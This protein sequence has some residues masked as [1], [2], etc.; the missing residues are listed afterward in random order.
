MSQ[1]IEDE[2]ERELLR[3]RLIKLL[4]AGRVGGYIIRTM[5]EAAGD[6]ELLADVDYLQKA[7]GN[8]QA[9]SH[10]AA[11]RSLVSRI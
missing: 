8:I 7:W 10:G 4:P 5:S 1:R 2:A 6:A 11:D 3:E 9:A